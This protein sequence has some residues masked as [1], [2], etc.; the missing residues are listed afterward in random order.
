M[1]LYHQWE[2]ATKEWLQPGVLTQNIVTFRL[3]NISEMEFH[4][5]R[6]L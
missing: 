1:Y 3:Q 2:T 4:S 5:R 6:I